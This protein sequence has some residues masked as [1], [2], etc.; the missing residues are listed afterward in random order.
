MSIKIILSFIIFLFGCTSCKQTKEQ[1]LD[2]GYAFSKQK[3]YDKAIEV[4]NEV[5]KRSGKLQLA[6]YNRGFA[7]LAI[8]Q[9][10][11]A[12]WDFNKVMSLQTHGDYIITYNQNS[13]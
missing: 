11:R 6:Y 1:L 3:K 13:P 2:K 9:Y 7:Y 12:L 8:K 4:Y 5:I 10:D